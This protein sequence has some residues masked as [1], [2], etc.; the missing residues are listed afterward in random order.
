MICTPVPTEVC[1]LQKSA[2][3]GA[4]CLSVAQRCFVE[5][6]VHDCPPQVVPVS[7]RTLRDGSVRLEQV[8]WV[9]NETVRTC[10]SSR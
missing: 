9:P 7:Q 3:H 1:S 2:A 5:C 10:L 4:C 8:I 6:G